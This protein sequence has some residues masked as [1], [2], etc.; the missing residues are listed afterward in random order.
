MNRGIVDSHLVYPP[1]T[2]LGVMSYAGELYWIAHWVGPEE[3]KLVEDERW[4][5]REEGAREKELYLLT[6]LPI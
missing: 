1:D 3:T 6:F 4:D 5:N 2:E